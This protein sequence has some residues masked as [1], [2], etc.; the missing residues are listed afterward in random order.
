MKI[1][2]AEQAR[3]I[4]DKAN[5]IE[6]RLNKILEA[7][8]FVS[9]KWKEGVFVLKKFEP[10]FFD[11]KYDHSDEMLKLLEDRGFKVFRK[12]RVK[13]EGMWW[14]KKEIPQECIWIEW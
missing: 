14:W 9:K 8:A 1:E 2:N 13:T 7:V 4:L 12:S 3:K 5:S 11:V 6:A 10:W